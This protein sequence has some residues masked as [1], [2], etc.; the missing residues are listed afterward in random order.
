[1]TCKNPRP[2]RN[3]KYGL[4]PWVSLPKGFY[5]IPRNAWFEVPCGKCVFCRERNVSAQLGRLIVASYPSWH[6]YF[7]SFTIDDP[8]FFA[9]NNKG[10]ERSDLDKLVNFI[11]HSNIRKHTH[12]KYFL[13]SEYGETTDRPH[14]HGLFYN[15]GTR[16][17]LDDVLYSCYQKG[18]IEVSDVNLARFR[19][20][21]NSHV[22][23]CTHIPYYVDE[24]DFGTGE[25]IQLKANKPFVRCSRGLGAEYVDR[26]YR[27]IYRDG[28]INYDGIAFPI[29]DTLYN[30]LAKNL[31]LS[32]QQLKY[33]FYCMNKPLNTA[34]NEFKSIAK[35]VGV[36]F[37]LY[38]TDPPRFFQMIQLKT[39]IAEK[40]FLRKYI[41]K[42]RSYNI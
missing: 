31:H 30:R 42:N 34:S 38:I 25:I 29:H 14:Y 9:E 12:Y 20:V 36:D 26:F 5:R 28:C 22:T 32:P 7:V 18:N 24:V 11:N 15:F 13:T 16:H 4:D 40:E 37:D 41:D 2:I 27:D 3:N 1:M 39:Q 21:A 35:K 10:V 19:Y 17:E 23:K 6:C 33:R 8:H